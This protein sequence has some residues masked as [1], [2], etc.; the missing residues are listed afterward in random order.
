MALKSGTLGDVKQMMLPSWAKQILG[1]AV[2]VGFPGLGWMAEPKAA[3]MVHLYYDVAPGTDYYQEV[4][5]RESAPGTYFCA[6]GFEKGYFGLQELG[7][8]TNRIALFTLWDTAAGK[9]AKTN[10]IQVLNRHPN[11]KTEPLEGEPLGLQC[12][13][14]VPWKINETYRFLMTTTSDTD[15]TVYSAYLQDPAQTNQWLQ[16][17]S[18][19]APVAEVPISGC[20]SFIEDFQRNSQ[21]AGQRRWASFGNGWVNSKDKVWLPLTHAIFEAEPLPQAENVDAGPTVEPGWYFLG[22][23]G[24]VTNVT[25]KLKGHID[26]AAASRSAP[27]WIRKF[28]PMASNAFVALGVPRPA[29]VPLFAPGQVPIEPDHP[30]LAA[31]GT[32]PPLETADPATPRLPNSPP[33]KKA[34]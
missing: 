14:P 23:G 25:T 7:S 16:V 24:T 20:Y 12:T 9:G 8:T 27:A 21:S 2:L 15:Y 31:P 13:L 32:N 6:V 10:R 17:A 11:L 34:P 33:E 3:R 30:L 1:F 4:I 29:L 22:T 5:P 28:E 18:L 19:R 26:I